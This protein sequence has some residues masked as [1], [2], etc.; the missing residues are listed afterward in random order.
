M[1]IRTSII[2]TLLT[3][4]AA[5]LCAQNLTMAKQHFGAKV[6]TE[7]IDGRQWAYR[8]MGNVEI[9]MAC[10][11]VKDDLGHFYKAYIYIRNTGTANID[12]D[13]ASAT[14]SI[15]KRD[16]EPARELEVYT[17]ERFEKKMRRE[18]N[19]SMALTGV[20][21]GVNAGTSISSAMAS[22]DSYSMAMANQTN[23]IAMN[24]LTLTENAMTVCAQMSTQGYIRRNTI[25]PGQAVAGHMFIEHKR[26]SLL[27]VSVM[28]NG[29]A[30]SSAWE[31][32]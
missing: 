11:E 17:A 28:I 25:H 20:A 22:G 13:P 6:V 19:W 1:N 26:C 27:T 7:Y 5:P 4:T 14:A 15:K 29:R 18:R 9:G 3:L 12:F 2:A 31:V 21:V 24:Q 16:Y 23:L 10:D 32:K 8:K 30:Y